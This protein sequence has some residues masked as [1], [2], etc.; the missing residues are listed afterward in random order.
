MQISGC[1]VCISDS[2]LLPPKLTEDVAMYEQ[3]ASVEYSYF[4]TSIFNLA[5]EKMFKQ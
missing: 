4:D 2:V 1:E 3:A 5:Y